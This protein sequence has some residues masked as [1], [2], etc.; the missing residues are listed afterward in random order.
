MAFIV[1][2]EWWI[3]I[4]T[5]VLKIRRTLNQA[6]DFQLVTSLFQICEDRRK[7]LVKPEPI[8]FQ[9]IDWQEVNTWISNQTETINT[10]SEM[11]TD[12]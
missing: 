11:N 2:N 10:W 7:L 1:W 5:Y 6:I 12:H 9:E 8:H 3:D 4:T